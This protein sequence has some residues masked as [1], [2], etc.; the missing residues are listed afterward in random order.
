MACSPGEKPFELLHVVRA[1][2]LIDKC[3]PEQPQSS[4]RGSRQ[5]LRKLSQSSHRQQANSTS[6]R[7]KCLNE[8]EASLAPRWARWAR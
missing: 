8:M 5:A 3:I 6:A 4:S 2:V 1:V 7:K